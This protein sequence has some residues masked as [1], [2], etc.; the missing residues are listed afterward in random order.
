MSNPYRLW[1][2]QGR[3]NTGPFCDEDDFLPKIFAPRLREIIKKYE[4]KYDP[5]TPVPV[6]DKMADRIWQAGWELF[7]EV[8]L[9]NTDTHRIIKLSDQ[10]ITEALYAT[11]D[12]YWVGAGKDA[13]EWKH[14]SIEDSEPPFCIFS[15]DCI[16]SEELFYSYCLAFLKEPLL[17]GFCAPILEESMGQLIRSASPFEINGCT[18]HIYK[19]RLAAKQVGRPGT[20]F[21]AVGTAEH[22][23]GQIAVSNN[24]WGVRTTDSRIIGT[25]TE[26]KTADT[27]LNRAVHC[28]QYGCY[29]GNLT[30]P[31]YGGW[32]GGSEGVAVS[33]VAYSLN[34]LCIY[35]AQYNQHFPFHLNWG[36]NTTRELLWP[37]SMAGQAMARNSKLLYTS[38]GFANAGPMTE[39]LFYETACHALVSVVT[40]WHLWEMASTRNKFRNRA[41]PLEARLGMEVGHAVA[42]Q[43]MTRGQANEIA[44]KLLS[45]YEANAGDAPKG[46]EYQECY[47]VAKANP[48]Q[49]HYDMYRKVKD[50]VAKLGVEFLY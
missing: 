26:F 4:I 6:D 47:D 10:E 31:I 27:L 48:T 20:F 7:R 18:E 12:R 46:V 49:E 38:N 35:G 45:K 13:V 43:G 36:S 40:G 9:Y 1:E 44:L 15:P 32:C 29:S 11:S 2:I 16:C 42:R 3:S 50:E 21:V 23:T 28:A 41:T 34:G 39:M 14:R 19:M 37:I 30:G 8:G 17:D 24:E 33:L 25:L 5:K 22:D